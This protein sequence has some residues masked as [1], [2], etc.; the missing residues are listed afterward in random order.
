MHLEEAKRFAEHWVAAW[1]NHD[2]DAVLAHYTDDF[3]MTTP[4]IQRVLGIES[5]TLKG[6]M[7]VGDYW[8]SAL[9]KVPDL[10]FS[11]IEV[12]CGV[13]AVSIYYDA[14]MQK[15]AVETFFFNENGKVY[16]ALAT[17]N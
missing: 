10:K 9:K 4:M 17:Y 15:R 8:R 3:E 7:A 13:G 6:K 11:L 14:V 12:T 5:G 2:I 16:K 1:N